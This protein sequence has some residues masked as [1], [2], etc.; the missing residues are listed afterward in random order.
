MTRVEGGCQATAV[1]F[2]SLSLTKRNTRTHTHTHTHTQTHNSTITVHDPVPV[3]TQTHT[4]T[5]QRAHTN[6][7]H[8]RTHTHVPM[9]TH[10]HMQGLCKHKNINTHTQTDT[11]TRTCTYTHTQIHLGRLPCLMAAALLCLHLTMC[12]NATRQVLS[13]VMTSQNAGDP[14]LIQEIRGGLWTE[15]RQ[16]RGWFTFPSRVDVKKNK[17]KKKANS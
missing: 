7:R 2:C 17:I 15:E 8:A 9:H 10:A 13:A 12:G 11:C 4:H 16:G 5:H 3:V 1:T 14:R 6:G